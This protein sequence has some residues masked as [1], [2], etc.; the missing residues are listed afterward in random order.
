M[1]NEEH[2]AILKQGVHVWNEWR[3]G[4][5]G[6]VP[7]LSGANLYDADLRGANLLRANLAQAN[8]SGVDLSQANLSMVNLHGANLSVANFSDA[9][10]GRANLS[11]ASLS[12][13]N[14]SGVNLRRANLEVADLF[15]TN[16]DGA[17]IGDSTLGF[18]SLANLDLSVVSGLGA[19]VHGE[20][21]SVG[22]DTL[23]RTLRGSG[24]RFTTEQLV[25]FG[26]AG[27]PY[28]LL[29][30]LPGILEAEP[31]KFFPCFISYSSVD[32]AFADRLNQD[33]NSAGIQTWKWDRDAVRGRDLHQSID[34]AIRQ[35]DKTILICSASSLTSPQV[36]PEIV[37]ALDKEK[38][39]KANNAERRKEAQAAGEPL[40]NVDADVL[41][42][43]RLD[44]TIFDWDSHLKIE[45]SRRMISDFTGAPP[46]SEKYRAELQKLIHSLDPKS[47][48]TQ[49]SP[50]KANV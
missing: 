25:F 37:A 40:P 34:R 19:V 44:D 14:L 24:G 49:L 6:I 17:E 20:P 2:L 10:L 28:T 30:Y 42:P 43:I 11:G 3:T 45:V 32:E 29:E 18:T 27:V 35:Y 23:A 26:G 22:V 8:L 5:P 1:A 16:F 33:L 47:W 13:T 50:A 41:I 7:D 31:L 36:E 48:P 46:G 21:S 15:M 38:R 9:N 4:S 12:D 39:I